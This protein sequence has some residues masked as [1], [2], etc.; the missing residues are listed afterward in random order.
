LSTC[1]QVKEVSLYSRF[2]TE[3]EVEALYSP[4]LF[5]ELKVVL[6]MFKRDKSLW[7]E[8]WTIE[9]FIHY[10]DLVGGDLLEMVEEVRIKG[11]I[12]DDLNST[13]L[14]LIPKVNKPQT[15]GDYMPISLCN[16]CYKVITKIIA[17]RLKPLLSRSLSEEQLGFMKGRRIQDVIGMV[18]ECLHSIKR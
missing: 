18:N 12:S 4:I 8:G 11:I 2:V 15:F 3:N 14:A 1:D 16:L 7:P 9:I 10:F 17:N 5:G 13:F 6:S